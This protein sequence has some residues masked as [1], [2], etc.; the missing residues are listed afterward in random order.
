M[1]VKE[2]FW[3]GAIL[4]CV[5]ALGSC[6]AKANDFAVGGGETGVPDGFPSVEGD[7]VDGGNGDGEQDLE[8]SPAPGQL[9]AGEWNDNE[10]YEF[11]LSLFSKGGTDMAVGTE[12]NSKEESADSV[13]V[14]EGQSAESA[15]EGIFSEYTNEWGLYTQNRVTI[16]VLDTDGKPCA[17]ATAELRFEG[18]KTLKTKTDARGTAYF[19][20]DTAAPYEVFGGYGTL[21]RL[22]RGEEGYLLDETSRSFS[23]L[24]LCFMIDT[25][26]SMGDELAYLQSEVSD[27]ISRVQAEFPAADIRLGLV[28]YR[29]EG[30]DYV[31]RTSDFTGD[32]QAQQRFLAE[33]SAGGGG[34]YP[35][36]VHEAFGAALKLGWREESR[37]ILVPVLDAP[38]HGEK[39]E[40]G[41]AV[42]IEAEFGKLVYEASQCGIAAVP[43][44]ASG[45]DTLTQYLMRSAALIT[46]GTYVFLT[47]D[48][49]IGN[50]HEMPAVGEFTVEYLNSCLVR[51][52]GELYDGIPR[53]P[54]DFRQETR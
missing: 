38:P 12:E 28:F 5:L 46:G 43:V 1:K 21:V 47:N 52:I 36:A 19:F 31:V 25:T 39:N 9:T 24:D 11:F 26:G 18:G 32:I 44:A 13:E 15:R 54:V 51:V 16:D 35:E 50:S 14:S 27:V 34:D 48:S 7:I 8:I 6:G 22:E 2:K 30:D 53:E 37:K 40:Q 33:Q 41:N 45:A 17:G 20:P 42:D 29:D 23:A 3:I 10:N 4:A 49:G